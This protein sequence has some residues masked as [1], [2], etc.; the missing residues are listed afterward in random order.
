MVMFFLIVLIVLNAQGKNATSHSSVMPTLMRLETVFGD[1]DILLE[2]VYDM[3]T[4]KYILKSSLKEIKTK[5]DLAYYVALE[6]ENNRKKYGKLAGK[7]RKKFDS[8]KDEDF[9]E[10]V[11][12][13]KYPRVKHPDK[14]KT[15]ADM[16]IAHSQ[17]IASQ[18]PL[19]SIA[20]IAKREKLDVNIMYEGVAIAKLKKSQLKQ[21]MFLDEIASIEGYAESKPL[22]NAD[23]S[24]LS[25]AAYK[26]GPIPANWASGINV[27]TFETGLWPSYIQCR[28]LSP[29][30]VDVASTYSEHSIATF[31]ILRNSS[32]GANHYHRNSISFK[33]QSSISWIIQNA[34]QSVSMSMSRGDLYYTI[35]S[36]EML[37]IDD[38]A[39]IY[40]Y[41][42]FCTPAGNWATDI[43]NWPC[44]NAL[45]VGNVRTTNLTTWEREPSS[46]YRNPQR[47][48]G[49]CLD[50]TWSFGC[51][52]DREMPH[53]VA[54]GIHP[55]GTGLWTDACF[56]PT[57]GGGG[58]SYSAPNANGISACV[59]SRSYGMRDWPE[60][61]RMSIILT[62]H[63]VDGTSWLTNV[64]GYDGTGAISGYDAVRFATSAPFVY[65]GNSV[66]QESGWYV[67]SWGKS[68]NSNKAFKVK[69]PANMPAGKH[70]R[71]VLLW[72]SNP[73]LVNNRNHISDLDL[74]FRYTEGSQSWQIGSSCSWESTIE[75]ID[76]SALDLE[77]GDH[78]INVTPYNINIPDDAR[79]DFF[80]WSI[81]WT[82]VADSAN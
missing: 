28:G 30:K 25:T 44:Y 17:K 72:D 50:G 22:A 46:C 31:A 52:G 67:S 32:P 26:S 29:Y 24:V 7:I 65:P 74:S 35:D 78:V 5:E 54:P 23:Y 27:A 70:L 36:E 15:T 59:M 14:T 6:V 43:V 63:D 18:L 12:S 64:D 1:E 68:D 20:D 38:F 16:Q 41:P 77:S 9:I 13:A 34:I 47:E 8:M 60:A 10:V 76:M 11:I 80:Y 69:I 58:T 53:V 56:T 19:H 45:S 33:D 39:Y 37:K 55:Y 21:I 40:P 3:K 82:W 49:S 4:D 79:A 57:A 81:G 42:V 71:I 62:A 51:T 48:F 66:G 75:V 2:K 61:V 73:D